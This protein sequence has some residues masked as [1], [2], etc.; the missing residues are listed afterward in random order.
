MKGIYQGSTVVCYYKH[1][2]SLQKV[3]NISSSHLLLCFFLN[4]MTLILFVVKSVVHIAISFSQ[5][6]I[7][8]GGAV[9]GLV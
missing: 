8:L 1:A 7:K 2:Y 3:R 9:V 4:D 6:E 5:P